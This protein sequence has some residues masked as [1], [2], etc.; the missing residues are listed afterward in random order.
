MSKRKKPMID[1]TIAEEDE[2]IG[3]SRTKVRNEKKEEQARREVLALLLASLRQPILKKLALGET[4]E[5][6]VVILK[7][8]SKGSAYARQRRR[9]ASSL[10]QLD[11]DEIEPRITSAAERQKGR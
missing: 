6:E 2:E 4:I 11:L 3:P 10:R 5:K 7:E 9:V 1:T 8:L